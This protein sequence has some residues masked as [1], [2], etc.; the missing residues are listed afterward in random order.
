MK[1]ID[2]TVFDA[3]YIKVNRKTHF[4]SDGKSYYETVFSIMNDTGNTI[5]SA[6]SDKY[7]TIRESGDKMSI[8][9]LAVIASL[10]IEETL[11]NEN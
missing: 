5:L 6:Y 1:Q 2:S 9:D 7:I 11:E 8:E 3:T 10:D 4:D